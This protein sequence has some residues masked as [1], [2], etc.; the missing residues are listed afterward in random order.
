M[1]LINMLVD[2]APRLGILTER[3]VID[4]SALRSEPD[5]PSTMMEAVHMGLDNALPLLHRAEAMADAQPN[6]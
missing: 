1:K 2:G 4:V 6:V 5:M 3:G